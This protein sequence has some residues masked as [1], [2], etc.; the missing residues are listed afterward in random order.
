M[1]EKSRVPFGTDGLMDAMRQMYKKEGYAATIAKAPLCDI[2]VGVTRRHSKG[3]R[4][5]LYDS[6][7]R[8]IARYE[9]ISM[10]Y[11]AKRIV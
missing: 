1:G 10:L 5:G 7:P 6:Y 4:R 11:R 9:A 2:E 8:V 3:E